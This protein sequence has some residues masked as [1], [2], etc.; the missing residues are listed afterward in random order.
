M[1]YIILVVAILL[2]SA[3]SR[4][5]ELT[6]LQKVAV[7]LSKSYADLKEGMHK[8]SSITNFAMGATKHE[9]CKKDVSDLLSFLD[10][11]LK[12]IVHI[13]SQKRLPTAF[14][15]NELKEDLAKI[16]KMAEWIDKNY[17]GVLTNRL[18]SY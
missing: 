2:F 7:G 18:L 6:D 12:K 13:N 15:R 11:T 1:R 5:N 17:R 4:A 16:I 9:A 3:P 8:C 14:E 10:A